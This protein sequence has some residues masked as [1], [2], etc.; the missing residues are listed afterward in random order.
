MF[1]ILTNR[2]RAFRRDQTGSFSIEAVLVLPLMAWVILSAY[3]HFDGL[4]QENINIRA[5]HTLSDMLSRETEPVDSAYLAGMQTTLDFLTG[6]R[7]ATAL[8]VSVFSYDDEDDSFILTWSEGTN[9]KAGLDEAGREVLAE[10]LPAT[11][12]GDTIIAV[13]TWIDYRAPFE[14]GLKDTLL[15]QMVSTR[16]RY[17]PQLVFRDDSGELSS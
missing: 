4:R 16:A 3:S 14:W 11:A 10:R 6:N 17:V 9:G 1:A 7:H 5:A 13:E 15:H 8:R 12:N 2:L